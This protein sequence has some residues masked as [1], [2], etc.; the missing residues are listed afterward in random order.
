M[1]TEA[2][3]SELAK[4]ANAVIPAGTH[5]NSR[6]GARGTLYFERAEGAYLWDVDGHRYLDC[7]MG[8]ASILLGHGDP[9]VTS[10][11]VAA[12]ERGLTTGHDSPS[13]IEAIELLAEIVPDFGRARLANTGTE[14]LMHALMI[15]RVATGR[16]RVAKIEAAYHGWSDFLHVSCWPAPGVAGA[17]DCPSSPPG[18]PGLSRHAVETVVLPFN[19]PDQAERILREYAADLAA[20]VVEP[21]LIDIGF[22]P[23]ESAYLQRLRA[24]TEELGIILVF[25]ELLTGFRVAPGGARELYGIHPD[26]TTYGKAIA[27]GYP[28]A[29][30]EGREELMALTDPLAGGTVAYIGTYNGHAVPAAA[31]VATLTALRDGTAQR[32][33]DELTQRLSDGFGAISTEYDV[34][35]VLG[36]GGGHFQ[37]YF[38]PPPI[39]C[40]R[41]A[42]GS[43]ADAYAIF[44]DTLA[45]HQILV[46]EKPLLHSALSAAHTEAD[47]DLILAATEEAFR[48]IAA[49]ANP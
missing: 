43:S 37:P 22:I 14:A 17:S 5:S 41:D 31:S 35:V 49:T 1:L 48:T 30:L 8:N 34:S 27:N 12:V 44:R 20:V 39:R 18:S 21:I 28:I 10:A 38:R 25:D 11:V 45:A 46:A 13:A 24:I 29:V 36:A 23:A 47:I 9:R 19:E 2:A 33:V 4:R 6:V 40:Y 32:R 15:A 26:L 7:L 16:D 42:A 3:S